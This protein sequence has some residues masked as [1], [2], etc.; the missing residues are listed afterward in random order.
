M[1]IKREFSL[2]VGEFDQWFN[3]LLPKTGDPE[4]NSPATTQMLGGFYRRPVIPVLEDKNK[5]LEQVCW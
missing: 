3:Y 5:I 4:L 2:G 1:D